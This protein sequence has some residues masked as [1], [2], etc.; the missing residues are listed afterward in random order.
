MYE[1]YSRFYDDLYE[2]KRLDTSGIWED[3]KKFWLKKVKEAGSPI[4]EM[5][6]GSGRLAVPMANIGFTVHG[7]DNSPE[8]LALLKERYNNSSGRGNL[9]WELSSIEDE[10]DQ[11]HN[12]SLVFA[13]V[14]ALQYLKDRK[15]QKMTFGNAY[16]SLKRGGKF[17]VDVFNPNP[18]FVTAWGQEILMKQVQSNTDTDLEITWYCAPES[19]DESTHVVNMPS[20]FIFKTSVGERNVLMP[21]SYYCYTK[22][23]LEDLFLG[24]GFNEID[25][26]G[27]YNEESFSIASK[28][29]IMTGIK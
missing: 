6:C 26:V 17:I 10:S 19:Y 27:G 21:A 5:A 14:S 23:E 16:R 7:I 28:R 20:I 24:A 4:L 3:D 15:S 8:M 29:I 9:T 1:E 2:G 13:A 25:T 11:S 18:E 22:E 12:Y